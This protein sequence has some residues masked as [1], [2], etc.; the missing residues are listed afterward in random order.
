MDSEFI[1]PT[2]LLINAINNK[3]KISV[4]DLVYKEA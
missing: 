2:E 3:S 4:G 1:Q